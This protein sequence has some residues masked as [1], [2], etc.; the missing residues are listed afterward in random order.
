MTVT[1]EEFRAA[2][3]K[4]ARQ[5]DT[6]V[7]YQQARLALYALGI[8]GEA[9]EVADEIKKIIFHDKPLD[10]TK[11]LNEVG[12]LLWYIDRLLFA[13]NFSME[14]AME[15]NMAKLAKR[16]PDGFDSAERKFG[17]TAEEGA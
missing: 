4:R 13:L 15:A 6:E 8:S 9:G 1:P 16:Y 14:D 2:S 3:F 5:N 10:P 17:F 7:D 12:D 11:I